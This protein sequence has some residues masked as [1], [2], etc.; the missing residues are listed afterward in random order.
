MQLDEVAFPVLLAWRL[1][2]HGAVGTFDPYEMGLCRKFS[3]EA[4]CVM[5]SP[6]DPQCKERERQWQ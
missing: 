5:V 3:L 1:W 2:K 6:G 4:I